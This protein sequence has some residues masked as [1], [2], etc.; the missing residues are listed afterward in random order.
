MNISREDLYRRVW[1]TPLTKLAK[2]FDISDVGLAKAC[3]KHDI[4]TPPVG[5]WA[6]VAHGKPVMKPALPKSD[7][8]AVVLNPTD[9][10]VDALRAT[11]AEPAI[12]NPAVTVRRDI[13]D[14]VGTAASTHSV[15]SNAKPDK[16]GFVRSGSSQAFACVLSSSTINRAALVLD[17]IERTLPEAGIKLIRDRETKR[18]TLEAEGERMT[19]SLVEGYARTEH[20]TVDPKYHWESRDC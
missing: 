7:Q 1:E 16:Y 11:D 8:S 19:F 3:R 6:K 10:R 18:I 14:V 20:V 2:E 5:Y 17:A 12:P 15:L 4:P 13:A 9:H